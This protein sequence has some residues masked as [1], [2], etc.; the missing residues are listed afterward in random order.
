LLSHWA[1]GPISESRIHALTWSI[2]RE[3]GDRTRRQV[4]GFLREFVFCGSSAAGRCRRNASSTFR[5]SFVDVFA[6]VVYPSN[7]KSV[8]QLSADTA[9]GQA[10]RLSQLGGLTIAAAQYSQYKS[11]ILR[12]RL[13]AFIGYFLQWSPY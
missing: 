1:S 2:F 13:L 8:S 12:Y 3:S 11:S 9:D 4:A 10:V 5:S 7:R 6:Y